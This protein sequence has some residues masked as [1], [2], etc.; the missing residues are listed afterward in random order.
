MAMPIIKQ[1]PGVIAL[2]F[3]EMADQH[4]LDRKTMIPTGDD[5]IQP[6]DKVIVV[7]AG[8]LLN[9]LSDILR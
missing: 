5:V 2:S 4:G 8:K 6:A 9:D 7:T 3:T 1:M